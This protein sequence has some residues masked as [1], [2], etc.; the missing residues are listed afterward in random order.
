[1]GEVLG[2]G[3]GRGYTIFFRFDT[4]DSKASRVGASTTF[5]FC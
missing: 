1:M 4:L 2:G 3:G 5:T